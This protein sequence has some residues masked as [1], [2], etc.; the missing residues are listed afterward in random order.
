MRLS[1]TFLSVQWESWTGV[2]LR[3][4]VFCLNIP[5]LF[6]S[7][8]IYLPI[9]THSLTSGFIHPLFIPRW[10]CW[11]WTPQFTPNSLLLLGKELNFLGHRSSHL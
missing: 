2:S 10:D 9:L 1:L 3:A 8:F 7:S 5:V 6:L 11:G 4:V